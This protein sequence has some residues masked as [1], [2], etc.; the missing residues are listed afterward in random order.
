MLA[1][2]IIVGVLAL[3]LV[4]VLAVLNK[5]FSDLTAKFAA[6]EATHPI[7]NQEHED[8]I[9]AARKD[10]AKGS[11]S[12]TDGQDAEVFV[13]WLPGFDYKPA[14]TF[15]LGGTIDLIVFDGLNDGYVRKIVFVEVKTGNVDLHARQKLVR[16]AVEA[17]RVGFDFVR[18]KRPDDGTEPT[19][20][21]VPRRKPL[22][23]TNVLPSPARR[24]ETTAEDVEPA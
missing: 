1:A 23:I 11:R 24:P 22:D 4:I 3:A 2:L 21:K 10:A 5:R 14:D 8:K 16:D 17:K 13:P 19:A 7:T 9:K 15:H 20:K 12:T 6:Y 18:I